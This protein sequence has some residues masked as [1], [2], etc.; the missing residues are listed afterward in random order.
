[1]P[2][3]LLAS[4][5]LA[6]TGENLV[7]QVGGFTEVTVTSAALCNVSGSTVVVGVSVVPNGGTAASTNKIVYQYS[8][9]AGDTVD[10]RD[11][12]V[13]LGLGVGDSIWVNTATAN[14]V[15]AVMSG[16]VR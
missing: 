15:N 11:Y 12:L 10:L 14:A 4:Q 7:Y 1:M 3:R 2:T 8:L 6:A 9:P 16:L 13:G 5:Q